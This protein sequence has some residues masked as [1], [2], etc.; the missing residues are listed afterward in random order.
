MNTRIAPHDKA[1]WGLVKSHKHLEYYI[2]PTQEEPYNRLMTFTMLLYC[3]WLYKKGHVGP[4][5]SPD[6]INPGTSYRDQ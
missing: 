1:I 2:S 5:L 3:V 6:I 4:C